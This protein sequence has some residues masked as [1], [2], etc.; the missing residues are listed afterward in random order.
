[1]LNIT[2]G[3]ISP[4]CHVVY[5]DI[6]TSVPNAEHG[7]LLQPDVFTGPSWDDLGQARL[8]SINDSDPHLTPNDTP[9][10]LH[11]EWLTP[12]EL[13]AHQHHHDLT[14]STLSP[15]PTLPMVPLPPEGGVNDGTPSAPPVETM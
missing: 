8:K 4:Q 3:H 2:T 7:G 5:D 14:Q 13:N 1:M 11:D 9:P 15:P 12:H 10:A 6:F